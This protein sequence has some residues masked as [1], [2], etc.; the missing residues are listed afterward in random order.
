[1]LT[2]TRAT[3]VHNV[4][5]NDQVAPG[6]QHIVCPWGRRR[7]GPRRAARRKPWPPIDAEDAA[8]GH[9]AV[10]VGAAVKRV[11]CD[12]V[13]GLGLAPNYNHLLLLLRGEHRHPPSGLEVIDKHAIGDH[14][15][16]LY[17]VAG[18]IHAALC[19]IQRQQ[20]HSPHCALDCLARSGD[21]AQNQG[22]V[23]G[24]LGVV[25]LLR[26]HERGQRDAAAAVPALDNDWRTPGVCEAKMRGPT[27]R[28]NQA[29]W[30]NR[31]QLTRKHPS[32][33][34]ARE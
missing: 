20:A 21:G 28:F 31:L 13:L 2:R 16:L 12:R 34:L 10:D 33:F 30:M 27:L 14:V 32:G 18:R 19:A 4:A 25:L 7:L 22:Q 1:M 9:V 5:C 15:E 11:E 26:Q 24:C 8:D 23:S 29:S 3:A 6:L 17:L